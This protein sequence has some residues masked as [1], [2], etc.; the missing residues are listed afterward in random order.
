M[1]K[2]CIMVFPNFE[3]MNIIEEIRDKYDPLSN[4]VR[5]HITL[6]FP[7]ESNIS[8]IE[9]GEHIK[10][11]LASCTPFDLTMQGFSA[12][13]EPFSNY[14]FLNVIDGMEDLSQ[15]SKDLYTGILEKYQSNLY[16][17]SYCPHMTV[18]NLAKTV[19]YQSIL[20]EIQNI[21]IQFKAHIN[22]VNVEIIS[23]DESSK[24]EM[25]IPFGLTS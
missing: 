13:V 4:C 1:S 2:R 21:K 7:F 8:S 24:I 3:N 5:P 17:E 20:S 16:K 11:T 9:L 6:V 12:S 10:N 14:L 18:G 19:D 25:T 23:D 15:L 22:C